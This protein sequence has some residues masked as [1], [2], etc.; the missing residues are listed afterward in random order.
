MRT[1]DR[2]TTEMPA[3]DIER[4]A[5]VFKEQRPTTRMPRLELAELLAD[6]PRPLLRVIVT[7][8]ELRA[9]WQR[10]CSIRQAVLMVMAIAAALVAFGALV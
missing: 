2:P 4:F 8:P 5:E 9:Q 1:E 7:P 6:E 10:Y 3:I